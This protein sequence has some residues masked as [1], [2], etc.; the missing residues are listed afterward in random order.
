M[1]RDREPPEEAG[2]SKTLMGA[3]RWVWIATGV[4]AVFV[5]IWALG[6]GLSE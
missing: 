3:P 5:V 2:A 6:G 1:T 4:V